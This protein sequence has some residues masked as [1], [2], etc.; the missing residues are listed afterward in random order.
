MN[1]AFQSNEMTRYFSEWLEENDR[2]VA[3]PYIMQS[4]FLAFSTMIA[5]ILVRVSPVYLC[6]MLFLGIVC[7]ATRVIPLIQRKHIYLLDVFCAAAI[8][9]LMSILLIFCCTCDMLMNM[10]LVPYIINGFMLVVIAI[11]RECIWIKRL[12]IND[13]YYIP[14]L[15]KRF[16]LMRNK[17][18]VWIVFLILFVDDGIKIALAVMNMDMLLCFLSIF[19]DMVTV[20]IYC[21][22]SL[23]KQYIVKSCKSE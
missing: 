1:T 9:L 3:Y 7:I 22:Y 23:S 19:F 5:V 14:K 8:L 2:Y 17:K 13:L 12:K 6:L 21:T 20:C 11:I 15:E 10:A 4:V 16:I 18:Y